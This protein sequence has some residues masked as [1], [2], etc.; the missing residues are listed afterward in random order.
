MQKTG[1]LFHNFV[2][3]SQ[4]PNAFALCRDILRRIHGRSTCVQEAPRILR[5]E[6]SPE[7]LARQYEKPKPITYY[8]RP[9][10]YH[11]PPDYLPPATYYLPPT[12]R[13]P[14]TTNYIP[15]STNYKPPAI[16]STTCHLLPTTYHLLHTTC[17]LLDNSNNNND[18]LLN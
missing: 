16:P 4:C 5:R 2:L 9:V 8:L 10:T 18:K 17:Y 3:P 11:L 15:P 1:I 13:L 6:Y 7:M 12:H 14:H